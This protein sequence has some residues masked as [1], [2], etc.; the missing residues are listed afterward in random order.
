MILLLDNYDSFVHNVAR[1]LRELGATVEV[2][3]SDALGVPEAL[4]LEPSHLVVSPGPCTPSEAGISVDLVR[5]MAGRVP[6]L[7]VCLG[8]QVIAQAYGGRIVPSPDPAHGRAVEI[9]HHAYGILGGIPS[10]LTGGLYPSLTVDPSSLPE[11]LVPEAW[12][13]NGEVMALRDRVHPVW[14]VQ[15]HPESILTP[16]GGTIFRNF[17]ALEPVT[18]TGSAS[19]RGGSTAAEGR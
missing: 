11:E 18:R 12:T 14:G 19:A 4:A 2:R 10:P 5:A 17:L 8:H 6:I 9:V 15:F 1:S 13:Q 3:R 7:G 16:L